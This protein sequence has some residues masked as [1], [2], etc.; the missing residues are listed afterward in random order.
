MQVTNQ[1]KEQEFRRRTEVANGHEP[2]AV[3]RQQVN[4]YNV[5]LLAAK[6][7]DAH[8]HSRSAHLR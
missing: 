8:H 6:K 2:G 1:R 4:S 5:L 3:Y 7:S